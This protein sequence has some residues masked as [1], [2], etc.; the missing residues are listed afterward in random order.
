MVEQDLAELVV[1]EDADI[2]GEHAEYQPHHQLVHLM[3]TLITGPIRVLAH[4]CVIELGQL[5]GDLDVD[6]V[7]F[8][9]LIA[10]LARGGQEEAELVP[11]LVKMAMQGLSADPLLGCYHLAIGGNQDRRFGGGGFLGV[12]QRLQGDICHA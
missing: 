1:R 8:G 9:R 7:F 11:D 5:G 4:Q 6:R 12:P 2:L 3:P 10:F